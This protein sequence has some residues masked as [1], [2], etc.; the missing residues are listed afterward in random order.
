MRGPLGIEA[1]IEANGEG[2]ATSAPSPVDAIGAVRHFNEYY[3]KRMAPVR[4]ALL[5]NEFTPMELRVMRELGRSK[6]GTTSGW[7][8]HAI[9][10]D[11]GQLSRILK[12]FEA[13]RHVVSKPDA[14]NGRYKHVELTGTGWRVHDSLERDANRTVARI[15][16]HL[17]CEE[18][19]DLVSALQTVERLLQG[20]RLRAPATSAALST[21]APG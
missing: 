12:S 6:L 21:P 13:F 1:K 14:L 9:G 8:V 11:P 18:E 17:T 10:V 3:F 5:A 7:L 4:D 20:R 19:A 15:L 16:Q 2:G